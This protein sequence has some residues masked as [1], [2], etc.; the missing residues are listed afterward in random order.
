MIATAMTAAKTHDALQGSRV[1]CLRWGKRKGF[2]ADVDAFDHDVCRGRSR[3]SVS[4][5]EIVSTTSMLSQT[6]PK[7]CLPSS[8]EAA[9]V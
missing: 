1:P 4:R 6:R 9:S 7:T 2:L 3:A 8:H 5:A